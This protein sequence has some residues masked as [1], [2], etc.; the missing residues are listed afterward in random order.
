MRIIKPSF[1][2]WDQ[3]EG[4]EGVYKQIERAGRVCYKSEDKISEN[5]YKEFVDRMI[6]SKH[7]YTGSTEILTEKGWIRFDSYNGEKVA[8]VDALNNFNGFETPYR[9][10]RHQYTGNFYFY[11]SLGIE[12][13]DGH[14][15]YGLFRE[16]RNNFYNN[17]SYIPFVCGDSYIDNNERKKTLGERMFKSP[18][19]CNR[20]N[21]TDPFGELIGF[22]LGDGCYNVQTINKLVFHLKKQRK[23]EYL[24]TLCEELGYE[25][26]V[27]KG[28]Y[29]RICSSQI[30]A[31]FNSLFYKDGNKY[32]PKDYAN[33]NPIM[34]HSIIQ[35]LINSDGSHGINTRTITFT[36]TSW[37]I[38]DW[39]NKWAT[40]AG[41][42]VSFRGVCHESPVHN[43]VYKIL[44]LTTDYT[45]NNDSR[46]EDSKVLITNKTENVYCVTVSTG[47]IIVR[48]DNG[49][50]SI[51][52]NC[53]MLEHGTVYLK[54]KTYISNLYI[55]PEDG[56]E[57]DSNDLCKYFDSPYS[58]MYDDGEWI[59]VTTNYRVLVEN[60]WLDDLQ[61]IC[62]PTEFHE[63]RITVKFICDRG[64]SHEFVRHRVFSFAQ[65]STRYCNYSKDKFNNECTFIIPS[66][67]NDF[68]ECIIRDSIGGHM[69]PSDYY[70]ENLDGSFRGNV[71]FMTHTKY[72]IDSLFQAEKSYNN[73]I[74][75]GWK[76]Q[77]ARAVLP[78]SLKTELVMTGFASDWE[79]FFKLRNAG[80][81]HPQARELAHPLHMEFLRRGYITNLYDIANPD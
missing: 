63:K 11:P 77:Q 3:E 73:L 17:E 6:A 13:T 69:Y 72:L 52:G 46:Y 71:I 50:T 37:N 62:E 20:L 5:T 18:K 43:P 14:R 29:Y 25:F 21:V 10:I 60:N 75:S 42:T 61:Y 22:W 28:N 54:C 81:A 32:I 55:H 74:S 35:G 49:V 27:G 64:V 19:H 39:I 2:I 8:T 16:S 12:V 1:E 36:S 30:G 40:V 33:D 34:I 38:I 65:E 58:K 70:R 47:L 9:I 67:L 57:E 45:I 15:M 4:L 48:G 44:F 23:I 56:Q 68:P 78:N 53:A 7:C 31:K 76:P 51:C 79:H 24:K 80:S 59:Y 41:Y 26:E 66:W